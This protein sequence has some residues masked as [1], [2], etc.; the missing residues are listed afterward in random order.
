MED[1]E[2]DLTIIAKDGV[3]FEG[4]VFAVSSYNDK[5]KFDILPLHANFISIIYKK[6]IVTKKDGSQV[7]FDI[8][9]AILKHFKNK[10]EI[11]LGIESYGK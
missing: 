1:K 7:T 2:I 4:K 3:I 8:D 6:I 10:T 5:G 9:R 11:Y